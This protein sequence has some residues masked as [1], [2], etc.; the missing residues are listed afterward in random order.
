LDG[1]KL[2]AVNNRDENYTTT[3][4]KKRM[5]QV[6]AGI[7]RYLAPLHRADLEKGDIVEAKA[8]RLKEKNT[9]LR[10]QMQLLKGVE[11][12]S[13]TLPTNR[14]RRPIPSLFQ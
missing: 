14:S 10:S 6:D 12:K 4:V 3:K 2:K 5:E 8:N 13:R 7:A 9:A 11:C 1:N